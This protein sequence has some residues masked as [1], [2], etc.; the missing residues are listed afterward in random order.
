MLK[1]RF[2]KSGPINIQ[3]IRLVAG[4]LGNVCPLEQGNQA[5]DSKGRREKVV[6]IKTFEK[7]PDKP[8]N[9][10]RSGKNI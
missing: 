3:S 8:S 2:R 7:S 10:T 9:R 5:L 4:L 6:D 1:D